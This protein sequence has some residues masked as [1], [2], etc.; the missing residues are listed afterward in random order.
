M[1]NRVFSSVRHLALGALCAGLFL[2]PLAPQA[3]AT[4]WD[5]RTVMTFDA[6]VQVPGRILQPGTY[7]FELFDSNADRQRVEIFNQDETQLLATMVA[8]PIYR[9]TP[10]SHTQVTFEER[11]SDSPQAIRTWF[12]PGENYG[13]L[14]VYPNSSPAETR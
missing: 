9:E 2:L 11:A 8:V 7:V 3:K 1:A 10:P 14:F 4:S 12:Y 5:Q 13:H 6:P